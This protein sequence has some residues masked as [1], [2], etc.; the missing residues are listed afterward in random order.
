M[1]NEQRARVVEEAKRWIGTPYMPNQCERGR[2]CD[3][4]TFIAGVYRDAK[5]IE[6]VEIPDYVWTDAWAKKDGDALYLEAVTSRA[7]EISRSEVKGGDMVLYHI[8]RGW[9]HS[10]IVVQWPEYVIHATRGKGVMGT[11]ADVGLLGRSGVR[12]FS[13]E[14]SENAGS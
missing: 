14:R 13:L 6:P 9:S 4:A 7:R 10:A 3:C 8:G 2:G 1:E 12:F 11:R 5:V